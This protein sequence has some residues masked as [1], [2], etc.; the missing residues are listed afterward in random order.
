MVGSK[1]NR[2]TPLEA[3]QRQ[4]ISIEVKQRGLAYIAHSIL[5]SILC[6]VTKNN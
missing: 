2:S 3:Q 1:E 4:Q 6:L 5:I